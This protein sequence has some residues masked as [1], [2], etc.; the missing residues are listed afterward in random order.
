MLLSMLMFALLSGQTESGKGFKPDPVEKDEIILQQISPEVIDGDTIVVE[1][2]EIRLYKMDA[3]EIN[4]KCL[5]GYSK[6][7]KISALQLMFYVEDSSVICYTSN[8]RKGKY[9][10]YIGTCFAKYREGV[11]PEYLRFK[12]GNNYYVDL[13]TIMI[14]QRWAMPYPKGASY[15]LDKGQ[16]LWKWGWFE[17]PRKYRKKRNK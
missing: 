10:R 4:Q 15:P 9:G 13:S 1:G 12:I 2:K 6:C 11:H 5:N 8:V 17:E 14:A 7:G 3:P 16:G